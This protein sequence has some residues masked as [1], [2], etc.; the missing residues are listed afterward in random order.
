M[1][2]LIVVFQSV[3]IEKLLIVADAVGYKGTSL[4]DF[5]CIAKICE[6]SQNQAD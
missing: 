3:N 2:W 1:E 4:K 5:V 6:Q